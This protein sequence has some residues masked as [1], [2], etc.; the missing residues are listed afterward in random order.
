MDKENYNL[1]EIKLQEFKNYKN[2]LEHL[3]KITNQLLTRCEKDG[4][5]Q[6]FSCNSEIVEL[7]DRV[8]FTSYR[9]YTL[10]NY[11]KEEK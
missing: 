6:N 11:L 5:N 8:K 10:Q 1:S 7:A 2:D 4:L 3:K 9:L